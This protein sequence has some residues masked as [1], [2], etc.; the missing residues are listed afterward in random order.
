MPWLSRRRPRRR[1]ARRGPWASSDGRSTHSLSPRDPQ[2]RV[3]R[4]RAGLGL[5]AAAGP[6]ARTW[7]EALEGLAALGFAGA[8]VTMPHKTVAAERADDAVRG[9]ASSAGGEHARGR[10]ADRCTDTTPTLPG[11]TGSCAATP[12]SIRGAGARSSSGPGVRRGR[13]RWRWRVAAWRASTSPRATRLADG[14]ARGRDRR[15]RHRR[16]HRGVRRGRPGPGRPHRERDPARGRATSAPAAAASETGSLVVDL[17]YHPAVTPLQTPARSAGAIAFGGI[18]L[19]LHQAAL[20]FELWTGR[21]PP[22]DVMSAAALAALADRRLTHR[23]SP[24]HL[25]RYGRR[26]SSTADPSDDG[27]GRHG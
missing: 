2:R 7:L 26:R 12:G 8:N 23:T 18:G 1:A 4:A 14:A 11:S 15:V 3:P 22:L 17:L 16:A 25:R 6:A 13:A 24:T 5:R 10:R 20:S 27:S 9:R 21:R 19:L